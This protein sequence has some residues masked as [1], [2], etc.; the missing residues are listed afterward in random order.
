MGVV[1]A[2]FKAA[3]V[4]SLLIV[5]S[6]GGKEGG[7]GEREAQVAYQKATELFEKGDYGAAIKYYE[8]AKQNLAYLS[9]EQIAK[10]KFRTALA[11]YKEGKYEE[12]I[13]ALEEF[14]ASHPTAPEAQEAFVYL[15]RAY[16]KIAPDPWRDPTYAEKALELGERFLSLYPD[17]PYRAEVLR[18][19]QKARS[20]VAKHHYLVGKFYEDY[21]YYYPA[22]VRFEYLL[23]NF[24]EEIDERDVLY[25]YVKNLYLTPLYAEKKAKEWEK[26]VEELRE[27][28]EKGKVADPAA[29]KKRLEFFRAQK[30]RWLKIAEDA[31]A[32]ADQNLE[33]YRERFGEDDRY[34]E[35]LKIK[36][37]EIEKSWIERIL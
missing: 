13:L 14:L 35:L 27:L 31:R 3:A 5:L 22:A 25:R 29:A 9:P 10:L 15:I 23:V 24:P 26:K 20:I 33:L 2:L 17:S 8:K 34:R 32:A 12:A 7:G 6:C 19:M 4:S 37:G 36:R 16:L 30:E 1:K 28:I 21:G 11:Y 18:L